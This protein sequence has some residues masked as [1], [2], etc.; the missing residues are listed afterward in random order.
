M[1]PLMGNGPELLEPMEPIVDPL[2]GHHRAA[3][4]GESEPEWR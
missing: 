3:G 4:D 2:E 1:N